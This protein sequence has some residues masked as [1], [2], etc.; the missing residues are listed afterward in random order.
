MSNNANSMDKLMEVP[1]GIPPLKT[2]NVIFTYFLLVK[3][4]IETQKGAQPSRSDTH[5]HTHTHTPA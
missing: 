1:F 3:N 4:T 2:E 5:T